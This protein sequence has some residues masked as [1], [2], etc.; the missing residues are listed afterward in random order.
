MAAVKNYLLIMLT[1]TTVF[2]MGMNSSDSPFRFS[3]G[4]HIKKGN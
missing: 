3:N 2:I 4:N 1:I